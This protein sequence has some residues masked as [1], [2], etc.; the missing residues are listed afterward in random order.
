M[1]SA[2]GHA[3]YSASTAAARRGVTAWTNQFTSMLSFYGAP[4]CRAPAIAF[5]LLLLVF[6]SRAQTAEQHG[7]AVASSATSLSSY[8]DIDAGS[9]SGQSVHT[10]LA[11]SD[12]LKPALLPMNNT[13]AGLSQYYQFR[14]DL[15][16]AL[17]LEFSVDYTRCFS[18]HHKQ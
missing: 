11:A 6:T 3:Q 13:G 9:D 15:K 8:G 16:R 17:K 2:T 10:E 1:D 5:V 14:Q 7:E 18:T 4:H 12:R